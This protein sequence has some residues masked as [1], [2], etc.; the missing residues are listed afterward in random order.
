MLAGQYHSR[1][2]L[3]IVRARPFNHTGPGQQL[4][5]VCSDYARQIAVIETGS[6]QERPV[7]RVRDPQ[8]RRDFSDVRDVVRAYELLLEKGNPGEAYNVA[9]GRP[10]SVKQIV[11]SLASL[12]SRPIHISGRRQRLRSGDVPILYGSNRKL[13]RATGWKPAYNIE[14]TLRDLFDYWKTAC[15]QD[16]IEKAGVSAETALVR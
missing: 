13:R 2:G 7:I 3:H 14:K 11:R 12:S 15:R 10:I 16:R 4:G 9:S 8:V 1:F 5:F 6:V